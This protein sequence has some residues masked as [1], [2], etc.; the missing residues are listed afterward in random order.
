MCSAGTTNEFH[1]LDLASQTS[2]T[3]KTNCKTML[4]I[5]QKRLSKAS[6]SVDCVCFYL[7]FMKVING[8]HN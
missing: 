4:S 7:Q 1:H 2:P 5:H 3:H 8:K 6:L